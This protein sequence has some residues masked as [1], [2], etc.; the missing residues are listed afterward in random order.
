MNFE[1]AALTADHVL[2][3]YA[4]GYFPMADEEPPHEIYWHRPEMR[5]IFDL[6]SFSPSKSLKKYLKGPFD[7]TINAAFGEVMDGCAS[8]EKTWISGQIR[9]LYTQLHYRGFA[10][11]VEAWSGLEL[12]GG[13]YGVMIGKAFFGESMFHR[14]SG[15]SKAAFAYLIQFLKNQG[16]TLLDSQYIND[17][18]EQLGAIEIPDSVYMELLNSAIEPIQ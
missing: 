1:P 13:L 15:A 7:F 18:T 10:C 16:F 3:A 17:F 4:N 5:A 8:R 14:K 11:S 12:S 6:R 2:L 9:E